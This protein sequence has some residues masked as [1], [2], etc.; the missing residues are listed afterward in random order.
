MPYL[1]DA[2]AA[3]FAGGIAAIAH[4]RFRQAVSQARQVRMILAFQ[5][6][7][8]IAQFQAPSGSKP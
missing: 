7:N 6:P 5:I 4:G 8:G 2:I 3:T 1:G